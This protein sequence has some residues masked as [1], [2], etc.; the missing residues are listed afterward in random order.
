MGDVVEPDWYTGAVSHQGNRPD[1]A[2]IRNKLAWRCQYVKVVPCVKLLIELVVDPDELLQDPNH[3][4]RVLFAPVMI[5]LAT[6][7]HQANRL[8]ASVHKMLVW[9]LE[10]TDQRG[11]NLVQHGDKASLMVNRLAELFQEP[12]EARHVVLR[13]GGEVSLKLVYKRILAIV[14]WQEIV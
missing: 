5:C 10:A 12:F 9:V 14:A 6:V 11:S 8:D 1:V 7:R 4:P 3:V 13:H 2:S